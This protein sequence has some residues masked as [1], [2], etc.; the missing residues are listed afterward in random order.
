MM[1]APCNWQWVRNSPYFMLVRIG[2]A[3]GHGRSINVPLIT[4]AYCLPPDGPD[5][6]GGLPLEAAA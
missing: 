4:V 3:Y 2:D 6:G 1:L 5:G